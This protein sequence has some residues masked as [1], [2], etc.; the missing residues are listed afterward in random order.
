MPLL[1]PTKR[2]LK[3]LFSISLVLVCAAL[4][5]QPADTVVQRDTVKHRYIPTGIRVGTD[6]LALIKS[7]VQ[8]SFTG[9]EMNGDVDFDRYYLAVDYGKWSRSLSED[10]SSYQ[11]NGKYW[12]AG[13]D[14]NF[15]LKD[16]ERNMFFIGFRYARSKFNDQM[17]VIA[18]D[19]VWGTLSQS[20]SNP[21]VRSR[22]MELTTGIKVKMYK[23]IWMGYTA[24]FKFWLKSDGTDAMLPHDVPGYGRTDRE[25]YW[26]FN[27]Q[28]FIRIPFRKAPLLMPVK[29][30]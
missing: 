17:S 10:S 18:V 21:E 9:W 3:S 2:I 19:P 26:G 4:R 25:T 28:I 20:F 8:D 22:W 24:R 5:A 1:T 6:V 15:L 29:K 11:N 30:K 13:I 12:R 27:Y 16:P 23:I 7:N 14:V